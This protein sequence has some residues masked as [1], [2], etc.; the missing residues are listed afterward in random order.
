MGCGN[1]G[2]QGEEP[3]ASKQETMEQ[4]EKAPAGEALMNLGSAGGVHALSPLFV[5]PPEL[6][7]RSLQVR[8][9]TPVH[10]IRPQD[11]DQSGSPSLRAGLLEGQGHAGT[12]FVLLV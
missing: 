3:G 7:T 5:A 11:G 12:G 8:V 4:L 1:H 10:Q 6:R 2:D 9:P